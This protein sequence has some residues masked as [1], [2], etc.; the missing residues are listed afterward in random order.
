MK[1]VIAFGAIATAAVIGFVMV[2]SSRQNS[3]ENENNMITVSAPPDAPHIST[4]S[5]API[6]PAAPLG[7]KQYE[8]PR[9]GFLIYHPPDVEVIDRGTE[10]IHFLKKGPTQAGETELYDGL[11]VFISAGTQTG[12]LESI[13][14]Q[15]HTKLENEP[16][17]SEISAVIPRKVG[18]ITGYEFTIRSVGERTYLFLPKENGYFKVVDSTADPTGAG[19]KETADTMLTTLHEVK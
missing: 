16:T 14:K 15:E 2:A 9:Y 13:A 10:G 5:I 18:D 6:Q 11:A 3:L 8:S 19:F 17:T 7:W 1:N 4:T 12:G